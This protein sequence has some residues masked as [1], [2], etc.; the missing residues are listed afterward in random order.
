MLDIDN[1]LGEG[2]HNQEMYCCM[3]C[4]GRNQKVY[5]GMQETTRRCECR[6]GLYGPGQG[7][8][9]GG[10]VEKSG[11]G[12]GDRHGQGMKSMTAGVDD[13]GVHKSCGREISTVLQ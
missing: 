3:H 11:G 8:N 12:V 2:A 5:K 4:T 13:V 10:G 9:K 6:I 1:A 7:M